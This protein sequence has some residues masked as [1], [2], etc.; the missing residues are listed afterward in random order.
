[1]K[2]LKTVVFSFFAVALSLVLA[3][4]GCSVAKSFE[5][6]VTVVACVDGAVA[7]NG[8]VNIFNNLIMPEIT[9]APQGKYFAGW[10]VKSDWTEGEDSEELIIEGSL[11]HYSDVKDLAK[12]GSVTLYPVY[13]ESVRYYFVFAWYAR[14]GTSGL[15]EAYMETIEAA[16][17]EYLRSEGATEEELA[18]VDVRAY[19]GGVADVGA[20]L[21]KDGDVDVIFGMG[22]NITSTGGIFTYA[23]TENISVNGKNRNFALVSNSEL[24]VKVYNWFQTYVAENIDSAYVPVPVTVEELPEKPSDEPDTPDTPDTP[25][26]EESAKIAYTFDADG[27]Y[28]LVIGWYALTKTTGLDDAIIANVEAGLKAALKEC[29]ATD[30]QLE[31]VVIRA[32]CREDDPNGTNV[33]ALVSA[34]NAD[35]DVDMLFGAKAVSGLTTVSVINDVAMGAKTDRRIHLLNDTGLA[36]AVFEWFRSADAQAL[37]ATAQ[38]GVE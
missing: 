30:A 31:G 12:D 10:S 36:R 26:A 20:S 1:M 4:G 22:G 19:D 27:Q 9:E 28:S 2:R 21:N 34:L 32:Y 33:A 29:G 25:P 18:L 13:R 16:L 17:K 37:F 15:D 6:D 23:K 35:G 3:L 8:T 7:K 5:N 24:S 38:Q 11:V 14:T